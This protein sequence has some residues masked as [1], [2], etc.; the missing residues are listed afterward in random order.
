MKDARCGKH[1]P[2]K[3]E[4][5]TTSAAARHGATARTPPF[6]FTAGLV[7]QEAFFHGLLKVDAPLFVGLPP[8]DAGLNLFHLLHAQ[9][10]VAL[11]AGFRYT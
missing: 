1:G 3:A 11:R 7:C 6:F 5:R 2:K 8:G 9:R 4:V 10:A